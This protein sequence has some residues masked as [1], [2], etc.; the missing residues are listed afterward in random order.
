MKSDFLISRS[1]EIF[2]PGQNS[3][4][5]LSEGVRREFF[6]HH[7]PIGDPLRDLYLDVLEFKILWVVSAAV[8]VSGDELGYTAILRCEQVI[9]RLG[10]IV[11]VQIG[12]NG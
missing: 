8:F 10:E 1:R 6:C 4:N 7:S 11:G 3:L 12:R 9:E 5:G 2:A